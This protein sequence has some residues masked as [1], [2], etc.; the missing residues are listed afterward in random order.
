MMEFSNSGFGLWWMPFRILMM[1][2]FWGLIIFGVIW[3]TREIGCKNKSS[4]RNAL[5]ILKERYAK[6]EIKKE[7]FEK[8]KK[9]LIN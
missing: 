9:D 4:R 8:M 2:G 3:I 6:G 1:V 7:E 5:D